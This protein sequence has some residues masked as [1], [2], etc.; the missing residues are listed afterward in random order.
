MILE[1]NEKSLNFPSN[2]FLLKSLQNFC[3]IDFYTKVTFLLC[4]LQNNSKLTIGHG[5]CSYPSAPAFSIGPVKEVFEPNT[6]YTG[7]K[8][9]KTKT[10][11]NKDKTN[12]KSV[13][14]STA[15]PKTSPSFVQEPKHDFQDKTKNVFKIAGKSKSY[16]L[17]DVDNYTPGRLFKRSC[18]ASSVQ[19]GKNK[20]VGPS[21]TT[22]SPTKA[23]TI[24]K[25]RAPAISMAKRIDLSGFLGIC[26][27][28]GQLGQFAAALPSWRRLD[29]KQVL[30]NC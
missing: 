1:I 17:P 27:S 10:K 29:D 7:G 15:L 4:A 18:H 3:K 11:A 8:H 22:Y 21:A 6:R 25:S 13:K 2:S 5:Q 28:H 24:T 26:N 12:C 9:T 30:K 14:S 19:P 23:E 16:T 20:K